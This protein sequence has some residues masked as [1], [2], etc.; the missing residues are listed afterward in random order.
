[1]KMTLPWRFMLTVAA[2]AGFFWPMSYVIH[3][4]VA[5]FYTVMVAVAASVF[6]SSLPP[7]G[8]MLSF[9]RYLSIC[10]VTGLAAQ[11]V[12]WITIPLFWCRLA[13]HSAFCTYPHYGGPLVPFVMLSFGLYLFL[14]ITIYLLIR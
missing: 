1:M 11:I 6:V 8:E 5:L 4:G 13:S 2:V 9:G 3:P 12:A 7:S 10:F 14:V